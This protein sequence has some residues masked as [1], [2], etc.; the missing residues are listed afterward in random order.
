MKTMNFYG[1]SV[2]H[3]Q[4]RQINIGSVSTEAL[5]ALVGAELKPQQPTIEEA[6]VVKEPAA[7]PARKKK[8]QKKVSVPVSASYMTFKLDRL[9]QTRLPA[10]HD[11][12]I[13]HSII[14]NQLQDFLP[15]FT[16]ECNDCKITWLDDVP[17]TVLVEL[18]RAMQ[19]QR[20]ITVPEGFTLIGI[21]KAHFLDIDGQP[22]SG[23]DKGNGMNPRHKPIIKDCIRLLTCE[24]LESV[25]EPEEKAPVSRFADKG[26]HVRSHTR[27]E[28]TDD[29]AL[30]ENS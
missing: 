23:L 24:L 9:N 16:G 15:L 21:L 10:L 5:L 13:Q 26:M 28:E 25:S 1:N 3:D 14:G 30:I 22:L 7:K 17:R 19:E 20:L 2:Y 18:A 8:P 4:S 12:L 27:T 11:Y 29:W 6:Q